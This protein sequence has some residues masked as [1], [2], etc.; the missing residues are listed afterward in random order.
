MRSG[1]QVSWLLDQSS[2]SRTTVPPLH[3]SFSYSLQVEVTNF[4]NFSYKRKRCF[5][6]M[7]G[8]MAVCTLFFFWLCWVLVACGIF[9]CSMQTPNCSMWHLVPWLGLNLN[10]LHWEHGVLDTGLPGKTPHIHL[11]LKLVH[12]F[13][14]HHSRYLFPKHSPDI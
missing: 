8:S 6:L 3:I 1:F 5:F 2:F 12:P 7:P 4:R 11:A 14:V 9:S 10:P 13:S